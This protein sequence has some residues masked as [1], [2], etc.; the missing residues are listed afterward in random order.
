[1]I[2]E[3]RKIARSKARELSVKPQPKPNLNPKFP[4]KSWGKA[5]HA[6]ANKIARAKVNTQ[7]FEDHLNY[8]TQC[9]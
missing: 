4:H 9:L 5:G 1:M 7:K 3:A 8:A 2:T 6:M